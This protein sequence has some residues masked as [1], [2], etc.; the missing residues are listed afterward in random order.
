[1]FGE[2]LTTRHRET[3]SFPRLGYAVM[4][5]T[6]SSAGGYVVETPPVPSGSRFGDLQRLSRMDL[7]AS[8]SPLQG[9]PALG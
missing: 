3:A 1:M 8:G 2:P 4:A 5:T 9:L 7:Q 6:R